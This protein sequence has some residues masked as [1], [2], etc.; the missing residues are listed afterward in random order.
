MSSQQE[1]M[2]KTINDSGKTAQAA[3]ATA[4]S[5]AQTT[6]TAATSDAGYIPGFP[7]GNATYL[8]AVKNAGIALAASRLAAEQAK[9]SAI[10]VA[11]DTLRTATG[12]IPF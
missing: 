4:L 2:K 6:V 11:K 12:E 10:A 9:Q 3:L 1:T 8:A 5:V 7:T